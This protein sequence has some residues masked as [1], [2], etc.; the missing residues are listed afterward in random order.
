MEGFDLGG[1]GFCIYAC[2]DLVFRPAQNVRRTQAN[3]L[4]NIQ[5]KFFKVQPKRNEWI[6]PLAN[7]SIVWTA[8]ISQLE[9]V[10]DYCST[11][12]HRVLFPLPD[13]GNQGDRHVLGRC[14]AGVRR[15]RLRLSLEHLG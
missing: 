5:Q 4:E 7:N 6:K 9:I 3:A 15:S 1:R 10:A 14:F 2:F 13:V 11:S 8:A 12:L